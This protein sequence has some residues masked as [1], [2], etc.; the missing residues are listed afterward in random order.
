MIGCSVYIKY[1]G[2][3]I[4]SWLKITLGLEIQVF[5]HVIKLTHHLISIVKNS[6]PEG[7]LWKVGSE[8]SSK[9]RAFFLREH[10]LEERT[11]GFAVRSY[12]GA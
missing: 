10:D 7:S 8:V 2:K 4:D 9:S 6:H 3:M 12:R 5:I 11:L 1:L